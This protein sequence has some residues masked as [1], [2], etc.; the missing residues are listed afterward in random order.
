MTP[1][2]PVPF[3]PVIYT[4]V[5]EAYIGGYYTLVDEAHPAPQHQIFLRHRSNRAGVAKGEALL[6]GQNV[7]RHKYK[8]AQWGT[9]QAV[10]DKDYELPNQLKTGEHASYTFLRRQATGVCWRD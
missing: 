10:A 9:L 6:D 3:Y 8:T 4:V 7:G 2:T 1:V 5:V